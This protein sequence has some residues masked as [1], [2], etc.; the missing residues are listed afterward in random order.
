MQSA[1]M[2]LDV[3][4]FGIFNSDVMVAT[5][6]LPDSFGRPPVNGWSELGSSWF[7]DCPAGVSFSGTAAIL[8]FDGKLNLRHNS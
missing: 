4:P 5:L 6:E 3:Y 7:P 1:A 2:S 8:L